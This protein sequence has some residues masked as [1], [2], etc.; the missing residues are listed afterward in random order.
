MPIGLLGHEP[1][2]LSAIKN[3]AAIIM[4]ASCGLGSN[5]LSE[6]SH[7]RSPIHSVAVR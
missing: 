4:I 7:S 6:G 3:P 5:G 2:K 1:P